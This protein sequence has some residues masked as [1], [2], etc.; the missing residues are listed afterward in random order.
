MKLYFFRHQAAGVLHAN[1]Y[2]SCPGAADEAA[3]MASMDATYGK[4]HPKTGERYWLRVV[5]VDSDAPP[6]AP[7]GDSG[8]G[9]SGSLKDLVASGKGHVSNP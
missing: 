4:C 5:E 1:P 6:P 3:M 2:T 7:A 9:G 8:N